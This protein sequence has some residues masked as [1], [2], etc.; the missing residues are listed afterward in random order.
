LQ[1]LPSLCQQLELVPEL[2][3]QWLEQ[4]QNQF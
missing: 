3:Q 1:H 2:E 4:Q